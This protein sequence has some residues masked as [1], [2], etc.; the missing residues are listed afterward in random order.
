MNKPKP[1]QDFLSA[2]ALR[3]EPP[4]SLDGG[5]EFV[6][7]ITPLAIE[8]VHL[9]EAITSHFFSPNS[10]FEPSGPRPCVNACRGASD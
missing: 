10:S 1:T 4:A 5:D 2:I 3:G 9:D 6:A 8:C 7:R